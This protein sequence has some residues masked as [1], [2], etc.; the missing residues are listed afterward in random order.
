MLPWLIVNVI[1][2]LLAIGL[3]LNISISFILRSDLVPGG[4]I[5]IFT[6]LLGSGDA[7]IL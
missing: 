5:Y 4:A 2:L 7:Y 6:V 3:M 1:E